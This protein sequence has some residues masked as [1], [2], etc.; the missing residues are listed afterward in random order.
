MTM[1]LIKYAVTHR[2]FV[3]G[4][5][6]QQAEAYAKAMVDRMGKDTRLVAIY[7]GDEPPQPADPPLG[8]PPR[9]PT[10]GTPTLDNYTMLEA[11]AA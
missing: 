10:P 8:K 11:R 7:E 5:T 4:D 9:A 1:F 6:I 3:E 2:R